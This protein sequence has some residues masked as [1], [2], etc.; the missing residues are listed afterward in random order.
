MKGG[1]QIS[2]Y[3]ITADNYEANRHFYLSQ[4]FK[5]HFDS[6]LEN[7]PIVSTGVNIE[8]IEVWITNQTSRF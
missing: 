1:A 3:E 7:L 2:D 4:D 6:S 8:K 5:D